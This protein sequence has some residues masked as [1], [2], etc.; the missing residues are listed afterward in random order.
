ME[1]INLKEL[2][3]YIK[4]RLALMI[5]IVLVVLILGGAYSLF[6][7]TPMYKSTSTIVLVSD[8]GTNSNTTKTYTNSDV[9]LN[10]NL[11]STYSEIVKSRRILETVID[12]LK[13]DY[14]FDELQNRV[15][16]ST[17]DDTEIIVINVLDEDSAVAADVANEIVK[18][19]SNE[20][21][22]IYKLQNVSTID[23]AQ[24]AKSPSN[25]NLIK[26]AIIYIFIGIVL[27]GGIVFLLFYFDTSVKSAE[28][29]ENKLGLPVI[30]I[31]PKVKYKE[32][33]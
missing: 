25:I 21:K 13:L 26:D 17:K 11:V 4:E 1:E 24:E 6:I 12:N 8:E 18:V 32:K 5:I 30:G 10:Q 9:Q 33:K 23:I 14:T 27:A 2:F 7:K 15:S 31:I 29:V 28:E 16:V 3:E 20:I 19:F 22:D